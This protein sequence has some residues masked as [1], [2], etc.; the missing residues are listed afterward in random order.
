MKG[1]AESTF[2]ILDKK[3][4]LLLLLG[5][6]LRLFLIFPGPLESKVEF[7]TIKADLRNYYWPAQA[8]FRGE[9]PYVLWASGQSGE[10]RAD[11][12]PLELL[13]FEGTVAV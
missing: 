5:F 6:A 2:F 9:N 13:M 3:T 1:K 10:F 8:A 4:F 7:F 11:M 12:T